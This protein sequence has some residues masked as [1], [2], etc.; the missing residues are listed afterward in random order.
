MQQKKMQIQVPENFKWKLFMKIVDN[1]EQVIDEKT[2]KDYFRNYA[3]IGSELNRKY[4]RAVNNIPELFKEDV[5]INFLKDHYDVKMVKGEIN[6]EKLYIFYNKVGKKKY[7]MTKKYFKLAEVIPDNFDEVLYEKIY[8][9]K[10]PN[11]KDELKERNI[12]EIY[13]FMKDKYPL[14]NEYYKLF[15][16]LPE[17]FNIIDFK[18]RYKSYI[19]LSQDDKDIFEMYNRKK[20]I[21]KLDSEYFKIYFKIPFNFDENKY[22]ERYPNLASIIDSKIDLFEK[23]SFISNSLINNVL[24]DKYNK[25]VFN[26]DEN[27]NIKEYKLNNP[28]DKN[29]SNLE[30]YQTINNNISQNISPKEKIKNNNE[31][32]EKNKSLKQIEILTGKK[33]NNII[34]FK[35]DFKNIIKKIST[36]NYGKNIPVSNL[37]IINELK[38]LNL[39]TNLTFVYIL[40]NNNNLDIDRLNNF[41]EYYEHKNTD[42]YKYIQLASNF[43]LMWTKL[44]KLEFFIGYKILLNQNNDKTLLTEENIMK[45]ANNNSLLSHIYSNI[46]IVKYF[47]CKMK[48]DDMNI[49]YNINLIIDNTKLE[50]ND[51]LVLYNIFIINSLLNSKINLIIQNNMKLEKKLNNLINIF[52]NIA[53]VD[54]IF[55]DFKEESERLSLDNLISIGLIDNIPENLHL[56]L[57]S[58]NIK[59]LNRV[60]KYLY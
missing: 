28:N 55:D 57:F 46:E 25:G 50:I 30:I 5:Y 49:E 4:H 23:Y 43:K 12:F 2:A 47:L 13:Y 17:Y 37:C 8:F 26:I 1:K 38:Q 19:D 15:Y 6:N 35:S 34:N 53:C 54:I 7:P 42:L 9:Y 10:D 22:K 16:G 51:N 36:I 21:L 56:G 31:N 41:L 24:D 14:S 29:R 45:T 48:I 27:I 60:Y 3:T 59:K 44:Y 52:K 11:F 39:I 18:E 32:I 33:D 58:K 40:E 20:T